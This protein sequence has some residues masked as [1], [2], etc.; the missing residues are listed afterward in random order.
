MHINLILITSF[1][2]FNKI[3]WFILIKTIR[4]QCTAIMSYTR[5]ITSYFNNNLIDSVESL[6][7]GTILNS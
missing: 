7:S 4:V 6:E 5:K 1:L 2:V 3:N